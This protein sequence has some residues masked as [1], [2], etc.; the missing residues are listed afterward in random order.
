MCSV[1][2][3]YLL[4]DPFKENMTFFAPNIEKM[5]KIVQD[6]F[7]Y[8]VQLSVLPATLAEKLGIPAWKNFAQAVNL[9]AL[10]GML[11]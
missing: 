2:V 11:K 5:S 8:S 10:T 3:A 6:I 7:K 9:S 1:I 4:G